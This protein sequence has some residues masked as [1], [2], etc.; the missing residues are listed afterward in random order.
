MR[1][2]IMI[3]VDIRLKDSAQMPLVQ[4]DDI[5]ENLAP[6]TSDD[7]LAVW[8]LPRRSG[9]NL[10]FVNAQVANSVLK[11]GAVDGIPTP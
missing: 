4:N 10:H 3:G 5:V 2:P 7:S 6:D 9:S 8:I 1:L 11:L